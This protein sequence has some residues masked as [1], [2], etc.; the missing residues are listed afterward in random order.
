MTTIEQDS[1][2]KLRDQNAALLAVLELAKKAV[3][4]FGGGKAAERFRVAYAELN[5]IHPALPA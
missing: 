3:P 2:Q 4:D 1:I 5:A